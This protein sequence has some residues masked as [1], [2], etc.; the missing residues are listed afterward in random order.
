MNP[1]RK[2]FGKI[3]NFK[4]DKAVMPDIEHFNIPFV[5][6]KRQAIREIIRRFRHGFHRWRSGKHPQ[7]KGNVHQTGFGTFTRLKHIGG[8]PVRHLGRAFKDAF[9]KDYGVRLK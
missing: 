4:A 6:P 2:F 1:I 7:A 3:F 9:F 5:P 8:H